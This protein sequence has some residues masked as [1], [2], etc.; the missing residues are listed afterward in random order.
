[1]AEKRKN[2]LNSLQ[3]HLYPQRRL[4]N[5]N[6]SKGYLIDYQ[7]NIFQYIQ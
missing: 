2:R 3:Q 4:R 7:L 5:Q 1:V 6:Q